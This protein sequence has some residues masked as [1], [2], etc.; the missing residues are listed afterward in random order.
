MAGTRAPCCIGLAPEHNDDKEG[1]PA[2]LPAC[3]ERLAAG[4]ATAGS[5]PSSFSC[6]LK[7]KVHSSG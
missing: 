6:W 5:R 2:Y 4:C 1:V 7:F 3:L